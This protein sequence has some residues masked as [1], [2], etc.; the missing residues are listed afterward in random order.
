MIFCVFCGKGPFPASSGL[1]KHISHSANCIKAASQK[2]GSY[3]TNIWD[4]I[5]LA[6]PSNNEPQSPTSSPILENN[7]LPDISLEEDLQGVDIN[8]PALAETQPAQPQPFMVT[9]DEAETRDE[10]EESLH[11]VEEFPRN[12]GAGAIWG[13]KVPFFEKLRLEQMK[14]G[15]SQW[16]P[17]EDRDEW[18]LAEWLIRNI[19]Q[20]QTDAFLNLNI[21]RSHL[22]NDDSM[23]IN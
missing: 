1:N 13:E 20:K 4:D 8:L 3:A 15:Y 5:P 2:S 18:E 19:G 11:Y 16:A 6:G 7:E 9:V 12:L 14:N 17:F 23:D 10:D 21:V 22:V